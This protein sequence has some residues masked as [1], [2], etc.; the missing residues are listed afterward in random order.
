MGSG[1][2]AETEHRKMRNLIKKGRSGVEELEFI[3]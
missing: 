1:W 2:C 3:K